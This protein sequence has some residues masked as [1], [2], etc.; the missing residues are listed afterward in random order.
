MRPIQTEPFSLKKEFQNVVKP[1]MVYLATFIVLISSFKDIA[2]AGLHLKWVMIRAFYFPFILLGCYLTKSRYCEKFYELPIWVGGA[3]IT[4]ICIYFSLQ[5]GGY[6]ENYVYGLI[7]LYF[8]LAVMPITRK[9]FFGVVILSII[10]FVGFNS[11]FFGINNLPEKSLISSL[12]LLM[13]FSFIVYLIT[14]SINRKKI[15][16]ENTL[17]RTVV[18]RDK[19]IFEQSKKIADIETKTAL[20]L[21]A[22][23]VAHDIRSPLS[24][25]EMIIQDISQIPEEKR[26]I[27]RNAIGRI[28]D[29]ANNLLRQ[30]KKNQHNQITISACLLTS[31]IDSLISEK[32]M[33]FRSELNTTIEFTPS[34][35]SYGLFAKINL[36][37][38]KRVLS[39][40]INNAVEAT[41]Y[42][43]HVR[44][45]AFSR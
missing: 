8:A 9:T 1:Y 22:T 40:L 45:Y 11:Y 4:Y 5:T 18:E 25:L 27:T 26:I 36:H 34:V 42:Q 20:G 23:Q 16:L 12:I 30:R 31:V 17:T 6:K 41:N 21:M 35:E 38:F 33:Q 2:I 14:A 3:Y 37:E 32:R 10:S 19:H 7:Q 39:N 29:I 13:I 44:G 15:I 24:A 43:G 28:R